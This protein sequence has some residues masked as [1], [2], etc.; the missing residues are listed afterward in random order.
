V[1]L[2]R[3]PD[4][5]SQ[6]QDQLL[7][8]NSGDLVM[9]AVMGEITNPV[10]RANVYLIG[11]DGV[12]RVLPGPGGIVI[13]RRIGDPCVGFAEDHVEPGVA[14][15]STARGPGG[16]PDG[17]NLALMTSACIGNV[18]R[19]V[20]GKHAGV[21]HV[22]VDFD[23]TT[24]CNLNIGDRIQIYSCGLGL[25]LLDYP[26]ITVLYCS[27]GL[28][29]RWNPTPRARMLEVRVTHL[30]PAA[31]LGSGLGVNTA[32]R[33]DVDLELFDPAV[34]RRFGLATLR[35]G[36]FVCVL[37]VDSRFGFSWRK[38]RVTI[39]IVAHGDSTVSGHGPGIVALLTGPVTRLYPVLDRNANIAA[40]Y[41]IRP[42]ATPH[43]RTPLAGSAQSW[44]PRYNRRR[45]AVFLD[46]FRADRHALQV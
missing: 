26:D 36:D 30:V 17:P 31:I 13:N 18:A 24:L 5:L 39:G 34:R 45:P 38:G 25:Q 35:F 11:N 15:R 1:L 20:T 22:L 2:V 10:G 8:T 21:D 16:A 3:R 40:L 4:L 7:R 9:Q 12:P 28:L 23:T 37:G 41:Q 29:R 42:L 32:L 27:P 19:V 14:L 46:T 44:V 33:G 6:M 43:R